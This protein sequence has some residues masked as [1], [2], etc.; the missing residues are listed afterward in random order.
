M[1]TVGRSQ[2]MLRSNTEAGTRNSN[3]RTPEK[4]ELASSFYWPIFTRIR[5][6]LLTTLQPLMCRNKAF[7]CTIDHPDENTLKNDII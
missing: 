3:G 2:K 6:T 1:E 5:P 4:D 7:C